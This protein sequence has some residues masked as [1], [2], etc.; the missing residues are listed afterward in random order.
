MLMPADDK[1]AQLELNV[2]L[3]WADDLARRLAAQ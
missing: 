2:I 1:A 3:H